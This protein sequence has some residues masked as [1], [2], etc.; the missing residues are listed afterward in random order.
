VEGADPGK[1]RPARWRELQEQAYGFAWFCFWYL[2]AQVFLTWAVW[3]LLF[4]PPTPLQAFLSSLALIG[5]ALLTLGIRKIA[6]VERAIG[7]AALGF[8]CASGLDYLVWPR[9]AALI[10]GAVIVV[11]AVS[12][13]PLRATPGGRSL[14]R[15]RRRGRSRPPR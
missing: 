15:A 4:R 10:A 5:A 14:L 11:T 1:T 3:F 12:L 13:L 6:L 8:V 2:I 7:R 9:R